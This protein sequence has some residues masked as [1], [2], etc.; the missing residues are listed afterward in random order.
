MTLQARTCKGAGRGGGK[1]ACTPVDDTKTWFRRQWA[2]LA[3]RADQRLEPDQ[4][5]PSLV[6]GRSGALLTKTVPLLLVTMV[7]SSCGA[8]AG[9][10]SVTS[11]SS[12][13]GAARRAPHLS[14]TQLDDN[15]EAESEIGCRMFTRA[16]VAAAIRVPVKDV[17]LSTQKGDGCGYQPD[18]Q[19]GVPFFSIGLWPGPVDWLAKQG[20]DDSSSVTVRVAGTPW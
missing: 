8:T 19:G 5:Q 3:R 14:A 7:V 20:S 2:R 6:Q 13:G 10:V 15:I 18:P 11:G 16:E 12:P 4:R 17:H 1:A 9:H